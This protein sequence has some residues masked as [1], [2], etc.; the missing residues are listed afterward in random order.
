MLQAVQHV[1][2]KSQAQPI[3]EATNVLILRGLKGEDL[4]HGPV[5]CSVAA[6]PLAAKKPCSPAAH[7]GRLKPPP[8]LMTSTGCGIGGR[9]GGDQAQGVL[10][11]VHRGDAKR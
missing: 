11:A 9:R 1:A 4:T 5:M 10:A 3:Q 8:K 6:N 2:H 7:T